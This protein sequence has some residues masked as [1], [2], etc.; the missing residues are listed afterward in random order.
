[1]VLLGYTRSFM[2]LKQAFRIS[3]NPSI[4]KLSRLERALRILMRWADEPCTDKEYRYRL[5]ITARVFIPF[6]ER[7]LKIEKDR[8]RYEAI[9]DDIYRNKKEQSPWLPK[10]KLSKPKLN[11]PKSKRGSN[12]ETCSHSLHVSKERR[13]QPVA[14]ERRGRKTPAERHRISD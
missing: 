7:T 6:N 11:K 3:A 4:Y 13:Q 1:M 2:D 9:L 10:A 8:Q 14:K 5:G 12:H